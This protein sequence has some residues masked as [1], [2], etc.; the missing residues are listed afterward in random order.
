MIRHDQSDGS[1]CNQEEKFKKITQNEH[2]LP[3]WKGMH[4]SRDKPLNRLYNG[5]HAEHD[6]DMQGI[7][8]DIKQEGNKDGPLKKPTPDNPGKDGG[9]CVRRH[10]KSFLSCE[11]E[12]HYQMTGRKGDRKSL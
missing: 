4:Q 9:L 12:T 8:P 3:V 5:C 7:G 2:A 6:G 10:G 1:C 11:R